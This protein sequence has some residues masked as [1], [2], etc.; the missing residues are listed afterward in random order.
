MKTEFILNH[1]RE[2]WNRKV[3]NKNQWT[4]PVSSKEISEARSGRLKLLLTPWKTVP[5]K[6]F[7]K[8]QNLNVLC[9]AS[10]GGQQAPLL[11]AAGANVTVFDISEKQLEQDLRIA[12]KEHLSLKAIQGGMTDLSLFSDSQFDLIFHPVSNCFIPDILPV[13]KECSRILKPGGILLA[14]FAN[15]VIYLLDESEPN[16]SVQPVLKNKI[17]YSDVDSLS[18]EQKEKYAKAGISYEFGHTLEDQIGGQI[19]SGFA[20]TGFYEDKHHMK[21]NPLYDKI[22]T[23]IAT[24][25]INHKNN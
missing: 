11:T 19:N 22:F 23:F 25:S 1:N 6:W 20:I 15:P 4:I 9:L 17:T 8:I 12:K 10:A 18:P 3:E 14:G 21:K 7:P 24:K 13:W 2:S 16:D 5:E